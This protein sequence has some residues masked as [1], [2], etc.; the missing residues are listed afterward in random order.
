MTVDERVKF[1]AEEIEFAFD[2]WYHHQSQIVGFYPLTHSHNEVK[3]KWSLS[4]ELNESYSLVHTGAAMFHRCVH[5][6]CI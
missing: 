5:I 4:S 2:V 1:N 6:E 3:N